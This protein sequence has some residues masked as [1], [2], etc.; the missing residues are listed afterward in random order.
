MVEVKFHSTSLFIFMYCVMLYPSHKN[1]CL[2]FLTKVSDSKKMHAV[3]N[4]NLI[5]CLMTCH[6][7]ANNSTKNP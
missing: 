1:N 7:L 4:I 2:E 6:L 3:P 5:K